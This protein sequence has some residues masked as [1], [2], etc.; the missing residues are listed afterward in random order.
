MKWTTLYNKIG[1][2]SM[3]VTNHQDVYAIITD[4]KTHQTRRVPLLLKFDACGRPFLQEQYQEP[5]KG[6]KR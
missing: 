1:K 5:K 4:S 6:R 2:Q 3:K